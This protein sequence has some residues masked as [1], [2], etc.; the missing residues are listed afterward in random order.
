MVEEMITEM[1]GNT[2]QQGKDAIGI[3]R[4][5]DAKWITILAQGTSCDK[6]SFWTTR[7]G[8]KDGR[9]NDCGARQTGTT[10]I[11]RT[12]PVSRT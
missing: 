3:F 6:P 9:S 10:H 1:M 4:R 11:V 2:G 5:K 12:R 8:I 7:Q